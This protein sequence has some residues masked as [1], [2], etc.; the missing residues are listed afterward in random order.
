M[1]AHDDD[2]DNLFFKMCEI[3]E[4]TP[5]HSTRPILMHMNPIEYAF[6]SSIYTYIQILITGHSV[7][8]VSRY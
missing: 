4:Y 2:G 7:V 5:D 6:A 3:R 8:A 1:M